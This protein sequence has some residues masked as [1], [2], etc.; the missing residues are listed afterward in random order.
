MLLKSR[1]VLQKVYQ[2]KKKKMSTKALLLSSKGLANVVFNENNEENIFYF[3][4][5]DH[6]IKTNNFFAEFISPSVSHLHLAD[7]TINSID[8]S[9]LFNDFHDKNSENV[10]NLFRKEAF[11]TTSNF[12]ILPKFFA[13]IIKILIFINY[14]FYIK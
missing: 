1:E 11:T 5:G 7:P 2:K 13:D 9:Q 10:S 12:S 8:Y 3:H 4:F 14:R 6:E